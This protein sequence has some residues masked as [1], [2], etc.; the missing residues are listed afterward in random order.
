ME[1]LGSIYSNVVLMG[2][3]M[4]GKTAHFSSGLFRFQACESSRRKTQQ[5]CVVN[6]DPTAP[7]PV[8][9]NRK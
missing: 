2:V 7:F 4:S 9:P 6:E 3:E 1:T 8:H 5:L